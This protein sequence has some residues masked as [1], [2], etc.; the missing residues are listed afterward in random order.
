M[1]YKDRG[2]RDTINVREY[3]ITGDPS[4]L[5]GQPTLNKI[6][7]AAQAHKRDVILPAGTFVF[8]ADFNYNFGLNPVRIFGE[9]K[10][11]TIITS[12]MGSNT[13]RI[14]E[15]IDITLPKTQPD[16]FYRIDR[17]GVNH[18]TWSALSNPDIDD[19][20]KIVAG[21]CGRS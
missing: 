2:R 5:I 9:G 18:S 3:G 20:I 16:G 15:R 21:D 14:V 10:G 6:F 12:K 11:R 17:I 4:V 1:A 8:P 13:M 19:Y 7:A